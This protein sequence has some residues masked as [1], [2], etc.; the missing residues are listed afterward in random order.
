MRKTRHRA[1]ATAE[2]L[3][4]QEEHGLGCETMATVAREEAITGDRGIGG[5]LAQAAVKREGKRRLN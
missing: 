5:A 3:K 1:P 4:Q 2:E